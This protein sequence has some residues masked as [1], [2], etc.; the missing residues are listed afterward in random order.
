MFNCRVSGLMKPCCLISHE[1]DELSLSS[2]IK[3]ISSAWSIKHERVIDSLSTRSCWTGSSFS[4]I[5]RSSPF[6]VCA[7]FYQ[8]NEEKTW[9]LAL[10]IHFSFLHHHSIALVWLCQ[11]LMRYCNTFSV[12]LS[13][14]QL[15]RRA[16]CRERWRI[17]PWWERKIKINFSTLFSEW[18]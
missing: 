4:H 1:L 11:C 6:D 7:N 3:G 18:I 2:N 14:N 8:K 15:E 5:H 17:E 12:R 10:K 9:R 16:S 13:I